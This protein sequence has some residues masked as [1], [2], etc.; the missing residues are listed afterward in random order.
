M[1]TKALHINPKVIGQHSPQSKGKTITLLVTTLMLAAPAFG[2]EHFVNLG[3]NLRFAYVSAWQITSAPYYE[4]QPSVF[5][6]RAYYCGTKNGSDSIFLLGRSAPVIDRSTKTNAFDHAFACG[7]SIV[8][9]PMW[10]RFALYYECSRQYP[11]NQV[12]VAF[13]TDGVTFSKYTGSALPPTDPNPNVLPAPAIPSGPVTQPNPYGAGHPSAVVPQSNGPVYLFYFVKNDQD[14]VGGMYLQKTWDGVHFFDGVDTHVKKVPMQVK[15]YYGPGAPAG[16]MF[17]GVANYNSRTYFNYSLD[18][19]HWDWQDPEKLTEGGPHYMGW[20]GV[21][22]LCVAP[23][24]PTLNA[25]GYG[26]IYNG[27]VQLIQGEGQL[28]SIEPFNDLAITTHKECNNDP[29]PHNQIP[30]GSENT[31]KRGYTWNL[32]GINGNMIFP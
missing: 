17:I 30:E 3:G 13:S 22:K 32:Y 1:N 24:T 10:N 28:R 18:G 26:Q 2:D 29:N 25:N 31:I 19:E 11:V 9:V 23:G 12:C 5:D 6:G 7:P 16:G 21:P 20:S 14:T 4:Y 27:A 8:V 15:Y